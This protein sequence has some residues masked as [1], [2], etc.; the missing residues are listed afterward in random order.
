[1]IADELISEIRDR[2]DIVALIGE[3]V[4]LKQRGQNWVGL[5]PFHN[6]KSPSFN[7]RRDRQFFHCFGC[8]ESGDAIAFLMRLEGLTFPQAARSLAERAGI[9]VRD[10]DDR[11][12]EQK[13]RERA[14]LETLHAIMEAATVFYLAQRN[15]RK[16]GAP[17][18][19]ELER[20]SVTRATADTFRLG[21]APA[22]WDALSNLL[23][24]KGYALADAETL[25]LVVRRREGSGYYD[26]FR[27]RLVFPISDLHGH[28]VAFS[29][30]ILP[31]PDGREPA[32]QEPKYVNSPEGPLYKKGE[33]L[34]GLHEARVEIRRNGWAVLCEGNFDLVSLHQ[35]GV[36][37][38]VAPLGTAFTHAQAKLLK[39][40]AQRVT[41]MFDGDNAGRKA[42]AAAYPLLREADLS[43]RVVK[44]PAGEDPDAFLR[45][46]G[47]PAL[48]RLIDGATGMVEYL[49]DA[50]AE[51]AGAGAAERA[52]AIESLGTVVAAAGNP[53]EIE[54]Y[55]QRIAQRFSI[56]DLRVVKDQLRRGVRAAP[57]PGSAPE[58]TK[59]AAPA[60]RVKL[61]QLQT[62]LLGALLDQP[63]L[64]SSDLAGNLNELL[65]QAELRSIFS[66]AAAQVEEFGALGA[67][68]LLEGLAGNAA[69]MWLRERLSVETYEN[70][71]KAEEVLRSGLPLLAKQ[72][73][74][75]RELPLL[76]EN[77]RR[78]RASGDESTVLALMKRHVELT[79]TLSHSLKR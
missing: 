63:E 23:S 27:H 9:E 31:Q 59:V 46:Q 39:R 51:A 15:D 72:N 76:E 14:R 40:F 16:V 58:Q 68:R 8:K 79:R 11:E 21:Y 33:L 3:Y 48:T 5:C 45:R 62:E 10:T 34:Y 47:A 57:R 28:V 20:R 24:Q 53:V 26:R 65:T 54:L 42:A 32:V 36:Q 41:V 64:F 17:A 50:A 55:I 18:I 29:G 2:T 44:L 69:L 4:G 12:D 74:L 37:N 19:A 61:P 43:A 38:V 66:A 30:R 6:E 78:A 60:E 70:R 7:V 35:A 77:I 13:R 67:T 75:E 52:K 25:G 56:S 1:M 73:V 71:A 49:I 22:S